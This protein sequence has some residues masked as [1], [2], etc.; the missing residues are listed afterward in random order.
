MK[1]TFTKILKITGI[2]LAALIVFAFAAPFLFKKKI[3]NAV[4]KEINRNLT[5]VVE[6]KDLNISLF[7]NFPKVSLQLEDLSVT[8]TG[9][10]QGDT[11]L[12]APELGVTV[13]LMSFF[14]GADM[15]VNSISV[16]KP[17][18]QLL[19]DPKGQANW[20][21]T[22][23][24][25][26]AAD[27]D[28]S[29]SS[30]QLNL[31][32]YEITDGYLLYDD[33]SSNMRAEI[34][35]L[36]HKGSGDL[37]AESFL[38]KTETDADAIYFNYEGIP[39][40]AGNA[41]RITGDI[42]ANLSTSKYGFK[43]ALVQI[44][45]LDIKT[46]GFF[47]L[48]NDSTYNMDIRFNA[49]SSE[50]KDLLSLVPAIYTEEF[51]DLK[52]SGSALFN[53]FVKGRYSPAEMPAYDV[54]AEVK[55]GMFQYPGLPKP[56]SD[57]QLA[58]HAT[59]PD[60]QA[61]NAV[62]DISKGHIRMDQQPLDFKILYKNPET[63]QYLDAL[64]KGRLDLATIPT[65]I[66]LPADTRL[67]GILD[68]DAFATG[69]LA[70]LQS[71]KGDF[72]AGGFFDLQ[73][74]LYQSSDIPE[75]IRNGRLHAEVFNR[76]GLADE[77]E[78]EISNAHFEYG[79][80]PFDVSAK[81]TKPVSRMSLTG[82]GNGRYMNSNF[83]VDGFVENVQGFLMNTGLMT[84]KANIQVDQLN[85]NEWMGTTSGEDTS[86]SSSTT[87]PFL[88][89]ANIDMVLNA[90]AG[91]VRYDKVDYENIKGNLAIANETVTLK[92]LQTS[93]LGGNITFNG[94]YSTLEN[95][96]DPAIGINYSIKNVDA[97]KAFF[98]FNTVQKL[99][100]IGQFIGGTLSSELAMT[101]NLD[102]TMMPLFNTLSGKGNFLL[103]NGVL[104]KFKP[105][106]K[107]ASTLNIQ[108]LES[109]S[110]KDIKN[111]IEF[112]NGK[113][114]V[115]PFMLKVKD[116]EMEIG[117]LH[118][119][120]QSI[121]YLVQ[122][123]LPRKYLGTQG[124]ALVN[125]LVTKAA[126][127][128]VPVVVGETVNLL[129]KLGGS[130]NNP[131]VKTE[132]KE[133]AGNAAE[134]LKNQAMEFAKAKADSAKSTIKDSANALKKQVTEDIKNE[135]KD[136]LKSKLFGRDTSAKKDSTTGKPLD[137]TKKKGEQTIKN[138][139]NKLLNKNKK[140]PADTVKNKP[141]EP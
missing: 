35:N 116:I 118:G 84:G 137:E 34:K 81:L 28:T 129:L 24:T 132:L 70:A 3:L 71:Q 31:Q 65:Y 127:K 21:I 88:V 14:K 20:D 112:A 82:K 33:R 139:F 8:G 32:K 50:F 16:N 27:S 1:K 39:W 43:D 102:G 85:L 55:D 101:G 123:K 138:T 141:E 2:T 17:R 9:S 121:D 131:S 53:G 103:L 45:N 77:T 56:V 62:L 72:K 125:D 114:L 80:D 140:A 96:K 49:P 59:N 79:N 117:G 66:K 25:E 99:M 76:S 5:A 97:Q 73:N 37:M 64:I 48:E 90:V 41:A 78:V 47:Q 100:P 119:I 52:T 130:L 128:G 38:L 86:S 120:D 136:E 4:K 91:K 51:K 60:G 87:G 46:D 6:F 58:I 92:D 15:Q 67:G 36:D 89:P 111:Y 104:S 105:L 68:A 63:T 69:A 74:F 23:P 126:S 12:A 61:D 95:K 107:I 98:A 13:N 26:P 22:K 115:K 19:V 122:M 30:F 134:E 7:K 42:D 94:T 109:I 83:M 108:E 29:A 110:V 54:K 44:N 10:F 57:I 75:T 11:L 113:V 106:E 133:A 135:I 124:N 18:I 93:A 40:L